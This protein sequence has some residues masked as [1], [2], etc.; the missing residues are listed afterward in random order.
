MKNL[1]LFTALFLT[2]LLTFT[3]CQDEIDN[4]N[5]NNPNTNSANSETAKNL[6]RASAYDGSFDDF[7]DD[8]SC[9]SVVLPVVATVNGV[10]VSIISQS[11]YQ[12]VI[13]ILGQFNTDDDSV[14]LQFPFA[15]T[16]SNYT[17][18]VIASQSDYDEILAVCEGLEAAGE[19]AI[20]CVTFDFP[21]TIL[22]YSLGLE[23]T[24]SVVVDTE[25]QLYTYMN[26][27]GNDQ[28]F[29]INYP[30]TATVE[31]DSTQSLAFNSDAEL[32][33]AIT[34]CL[35]IEGLE[36]QAQNTADELELILVDGVFQ[37]ESVIDAGVDTAID[38]A[39][40]TLDFANDLSVVAENVVSTTVQD[41]LGTYQVT[42]ETEVF[43]N[44]SFTG[45]L[46][47]NLL[48]QNWAVTSF[49]STSISLQSTTNAALTL[50]LTQI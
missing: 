43:L 33:A 22:T 49:S 36:E 5:G 11:D 12:Q 14:V 50:V 45:N 20:A 6:E 4:E 47:F 13:D 7:L 25:Q 10:Q 30:I 17:E 28:L 19:S 32:Q 1:K 8:T 3:S 37:V 40:F 31:G 38:F 46:A 16:L 9:S 44:L 26:D 41:V 21:I 18:V 24:G 27:F 34:D 15:V 23:Q 42:S 29:A 48:N 2:S 35:G 39:E